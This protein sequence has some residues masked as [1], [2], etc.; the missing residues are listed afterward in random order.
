MR[1]SGPLSAIDYIGLSYLKKLK[2]LISPELHAC[3]LYENS[4]CIENSENA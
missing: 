4:E 3:I 2:E 1:R